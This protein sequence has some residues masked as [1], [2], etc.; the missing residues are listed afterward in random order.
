M[1]LSKRTRRAVYI[2]LSVLTVL[3][4]IA[5][6]IWFDTGPALHSAVL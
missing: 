3:L 6:S 2:L 4:I 1:A 5:I